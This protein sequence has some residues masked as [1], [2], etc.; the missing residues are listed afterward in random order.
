MKKYYIVCCFIFIFVLC[1]SGCESLKSKPNKALYENAYN[2]ACINN[3]LYEDIDNKLTISKYEYNNEIGEYKTV[4]DPVWDSDDVL[5]KTLKET[6]F[7]E[8]T[9]N[10]NYKYTYIINYVP[11]KT[12]TFKIYK[13]EKIISLYA[14][15]SNSLESVS[16]ERFYKTSDEQFDLIISIIESKF[17]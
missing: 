17:D 7:V 1:L 15:V 11:A 10:S 14:I 6:R 3:F 5:Y 8:I 16:R 12:G 2:L 9:K 4:T 13:T